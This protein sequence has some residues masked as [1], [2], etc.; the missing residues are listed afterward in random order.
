MLNVLMHS[1]LG[2]TIAVVTRYFGGI[3]LGTGGLVPAYS[4]SVS[5]A[6]KQVR[7][8]EQQ[9]TTPLTIK[10]PYN[11]QGKLDHYLAIAGISIAGKSF[12]IDVASGCLLWVPTPLR[13]LL[14]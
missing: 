13:F 3:K 1:E 5:E 4:Q 11:C 6:L 8:A 9:I 12:D 2:N 14:A 10:F 7:T